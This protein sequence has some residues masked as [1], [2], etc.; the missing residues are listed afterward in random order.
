MRIDVV[1]V[2]SIGSVVVVASTDAL[3]TTSEDTPELEKLY[4]SPV[5]VPPVGLSRPYAYI[6]YAP[7]TV[8]AIAETLNVAV[9]P[10]SESNGPP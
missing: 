7:S 9:R 3:P 5:H 2:D 10:P 4:E 1:V 6:E 8:G